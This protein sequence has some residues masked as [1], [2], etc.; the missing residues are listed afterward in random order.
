MHFLTSR[1]EAPTNIEKKLITES[2]QKSPTPFK[3]KKTQSEIEKIKMKSVRLPIF[4][5]KYNRN[6]RTDPK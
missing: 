5:Q 2:D 6:P 4:F 1:N 3:T